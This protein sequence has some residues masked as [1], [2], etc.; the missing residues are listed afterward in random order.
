MKRLFSLYLFLIFCLPAFSDSKDSLLLDIFYF[1]KEVIMVYNLDAKIEKL[2]YEVSDTPC[3]L[4]RIVNKN[5][6]N[7]LQLEIHNKENIIILPIFTM[8]PGISDVTAAI[9]PLFN[10]VY[11]QTEITGGSFSYIIIIN[12]N[13]GKIKIYKITYMPHGGGIN[14]GPD[15]NDY[16]IEYDLKIKSFNYSLF[17]NESGGWIYDK[18]IISDEL[19]NYLSHEQLRLLRNAF[20]A[21]HGYVF[22]AVDLKEFY[23]GYDWYIKD[24][25]FSENDFNKV[26]IENINKIKNYEK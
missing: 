4:Y 19:L 21:K 15:V 14:T 17:M 6:A 12:T 10:K 5:N 25:N 2:G 1:H 24:N 8:P 7:Q 23:Q 11:F 18:E 26:E 16:V 20:Y 3:L 9:D 13:E 22:K